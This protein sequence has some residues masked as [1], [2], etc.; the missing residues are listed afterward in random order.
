MA[1]LGGMRVPRRPALLALAA[2]VAIGV[3]MPAP[4]AAAGAY[5]DFDCKPSRAHPHPV[6]LVHGTFAN[7]QLNWGYVAPRL[8]D[9]GY[10]VFALDY[11]VRNGVGATDGIRKSA[12]QLRTYV[13][14]V[15]RATGARRVQIVG[16]SQGGM[17]PR[18]YLRFLAGARYVEDLVGLAPSNHGTDIA[19]GVNSPLCPACGQQAT[20]SS[21][22]RTL[23][24]GRDVEKGVD[25]TVIQTRFDT[26]VV[27][28]RSAF[29]AGPRSQ[30]TNVLLQRACPR[31]AANHALVAFDPVVVQWIRN[32]LERSGPANPRFRPRCA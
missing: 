23:N 10:C 30:V 14:R 20:E 32:A 16:H 11:G 22:M 7:A 28:Y 19:V 5:N 13:N 1:K 2:A 31:N 25:Y 12:A 6:V 4:A 26:T 27:P 8:A 21:F 15:R 17:M 18:Y 24:R 29:L 9:A 3:L